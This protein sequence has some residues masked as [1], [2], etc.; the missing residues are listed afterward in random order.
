MEKAHAAARALLR[1]K[2]HANRARP[3]AP[4]RET[5]AL[6]RRPR[7]DRALVVRTADVA[8]REVGDGKRR[9]RSKQ[10]VGR[11]ASTAFQPICGTRS[12][13]EPRHPSGDEPEPVARALRRSRRTAAACRGRCRGREARRAS[14]SRML[15]APARAARP[16][17]RNAPTPGS[18]S[19][20]RLERARA[21]RSRS[22]TAAPAVRAPWRA[23][24]DCR[25]RSRRWY[26]VHASASLSASRQ[27]SRI[28]AHGPTPMRSASPI[29]AASVGQIECGSPRERRA[30][31]RRAR[32]AARDAPPRAHRARSTKLAAEGS[33]ASPSARSAAAAARGSRPRARRAP[34]P[35]RHVV[36]SSAASAARSASAFTL[37]GPRALLD[38]GRSAPAR[39][40]RSRRAARPDR[41]P[42]RTCAA[43]AAAH[44]RGARSSAI[45]RAG[46]LGV[47][48]VEEHDAR[49]RR[50]RRTPPRAREIGVPV[51]LFGVQR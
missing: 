41:T 15:R 9:A 31:A 28:I 37:Y 49:A 29:A 4:R 26:D 22:P 14:A 5:V 11:A 30:P 12:R 24:A 38:L 47:R 6:V 18:T 51:G 35:P 33:G 7:D 3:R 2:L 42:W 13:V 36:A 39:R 44:R 17:R 16:P 48:L 1:V 43:R 20:S 8:V 32:A 25:R 27:P 10:R 23:S 21:D 45:V 40:R 46:E 50:R 34:H 19:T